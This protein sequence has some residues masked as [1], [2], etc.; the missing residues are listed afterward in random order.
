MMIMRMMMMSLMSRVLMMMLMMLM[1]RI[2]MMINNHVNKFVE[3]QPMGSPHYETLYAIYAPF[4]AGSIY[5]SGPIPSASDALC[6][7]IYL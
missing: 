3:N 7:F 6:C 4:S 5:R 2:I 1:M